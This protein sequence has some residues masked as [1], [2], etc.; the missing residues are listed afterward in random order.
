[1]PATVRA[2]AGND[3]FEKFNSPCFGMNLQDTK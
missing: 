3:R 2:K 1:M